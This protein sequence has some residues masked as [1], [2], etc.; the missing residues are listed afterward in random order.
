[1]LYNEAS[2]ASLD[3]LFLHKFLLGISDNNYK[4]MRN[5]F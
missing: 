5:G 4:K 1:M 3:G 2:V